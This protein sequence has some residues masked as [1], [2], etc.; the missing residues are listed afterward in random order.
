MHRVGFSLG[1]VPRVVIRSDG[2]GDGPSSQSVSQSVRQSSV[3][4][5][6][7][8]SHAAALCSWRRRGAELH[9]S[10]TRMSAHQRGGNRTA[11]SQPLPAALRACRC[12][13]VAHPPMSRHS[14]DANR[15]RT[16]LAHAHRLNTRAYTRTRTHCT[17]TTR[18]CTSLHAATLLSSP[19]P[20]PPAAGWPRRRRGVDHS[21]HPLQ[22][23]QHTRQSH[24]QHQRE[25]HRC[26]RTD[27]VRP[28]R[29]R[30][31]AVMALATV[32]ATAAVAE[33]SV[34]VALCLPW[35]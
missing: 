9:A 27:R 13:P 1:L 26:P 19:P 20:L 14:L 6:A 24:R 18:H 35:T 12:P 31:A 28:P 32:T 33:V 7:H 4:H 2:D 34:P 15:A 16:S 3:A 21:P 22:R 25:I 29:R 17:H 23:R 5:L 30:P 11:T 10:S 8:R